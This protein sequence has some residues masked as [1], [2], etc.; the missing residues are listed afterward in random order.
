MAT[1]DNQVLVITGAASGIGKAMTYDA[2]AAGGRVIAVDMHA[3]RLAEVAATSTQIVPVQADLT[4]ASG[5]DA[6]A[7]AVATERR[8]DALI[9][10]AGIMDGF[11]PVTEVD[12]DLWDRVIAVNLTAPMMLMRALMPTM[13]AAGAGSVVNISSLAGLVGSAAGAAYTS[14]KHGLIGLT[15]HAAV[16]YAADGIRVNAI[17]PGGVATNIAEGGAVPAVP[18]A[19]QRMQP[20][21]NRPT[22]MAEPGDVGSLA[23]YL[24]SPAGINVN[25][26]V[27]SSD[28]GWSAS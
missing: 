4:D 26:A 25:G 8:V 17:C 28:G 22:R 1:F 6:V 18:W 3:E 7:A 2:V 13:I 10:N 14:S 12:N 15:K 16:M 27:I 23:L 19:W 21:M 9:N 5:I 20:M 11:V 24:A